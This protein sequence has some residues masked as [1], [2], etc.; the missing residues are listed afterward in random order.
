M[1]TRLY[2]YENTALLAEI[3]R[4]PLLNQ[5]LKKINK[6]VFVWAKQI[7]KW[8]MPKLFSNVKLLWT[9]LWMWN[10][11]YWEILVNKRA[12]PW[13]FAKT[14]RDRHFTVGWP[15]SLKLSTSFS[16][17]LIFQ[18]QVHYSYF[19]LAL[20]RWPMQELLKR[21]SKFDDP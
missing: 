15:K 7:R 21:N 1:R 12:F 5:L 9:N 18:K 4:F 3:L 2:Y 19:R 16:F 10:L 13:N 6:V 20:L 17:L 14:L 8:H 11:W